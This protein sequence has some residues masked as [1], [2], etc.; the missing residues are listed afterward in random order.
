M[1]KT[2][3]AILNNKTFDYIIVGSGSAGA[4]LASRLCEKGGNTVLL[5]EAGGEPRGIWFK[6]P[7]GIGKI[8]HKDKY[9]WKFFSEQGK[10]IKNRKLYIPQGKILGGSSSVNGLV[11]SRGLPA[12][13]NEWARM[14]C[15]GWSFKEVLP[16]FKRMEDYPNGDEDTRGIGG[17]LKITEVSPKD[18]LSEAFKC[19]CLQAGYPEI[20]D[21]N[22]FEGEGV[23]YL[24]LNTR[25]GVRESTLSSYLQK[26]KFK[27]KIDSFYI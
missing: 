14:G 7:L 23:S 1:L 5:L 17:P 8:L 22:A 12:K 20:D 16:F 11:Y 25:N 15:P 13:F 10:G 21:Y 19:S 26:N 18:K 9:V 6:I 27:H 24:Q 3:K 2:N 4:T